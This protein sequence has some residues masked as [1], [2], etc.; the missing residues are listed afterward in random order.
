MLARTVFATGALLAAVTFAPGTASAQDAGRGA[1]LYRELPGQPAVGS[2]SSCHGEPV[3]NRNSVLRGAAGP[4]LISKTIAAVA[5]M[6][7]LRQYLTDADLAD[8]SAYLATIIPA[9]PVD[10]LPEPWP[11]TDEFG[12]QL[13]GTQSSARVILIR[14]LQPR[15]DIAIGT[16]LSSD[17]VNFPIQHDCPLSLPPFAQCRATTW[18]RPAQVGPASA[19]FTVVDTGSRVL[20]SGTLNGTGAAVAPATLAWA[21]N[22]PSLVDFGQVPVGQAAR[23]ELMLINSTA[24]AATLA[25]LR[26]T[27]PNASRFMLEAHCAPA[28][29][30]EGSA[31]CVVTL[32]FTPSSAGRAEGWIELVTDASNAPLVR[33]AAAGVATPNTQ[34]AASAPGGGSGG[35][36]MSAHWVAMLLAA[37]LAL[38]IQRSP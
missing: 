2:C 32:G 31:T 20:R 28:G 22:T 23:R 30:I 17:P 5:R 29:R 11:T 37:V 34:P 38:R 21:T 1:S 26:V 15:G 14:N 3:N 9:G 18:F 13:V 10:S 25:T 7:F 4:D 27:G 35:G 8:I 33:I 24:I 16:V 12:A 36:A 6:G 19:T